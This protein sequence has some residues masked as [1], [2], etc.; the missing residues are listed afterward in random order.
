M[1]WTEIY[2]EGYGEDLTGKCGGNIGCER[3]YL[4]LCCSY[5][6]ECSCFHGALIENDSYMLVLRTLFSA[7]SISKVEKSES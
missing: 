2:S 1:I 3:V 6:A 4:C 7:K 5:L